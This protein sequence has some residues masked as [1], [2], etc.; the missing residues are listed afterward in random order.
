MTQKKLKSD[1]VIKEIKYE[2]IRK[3]KQ[4]FDDLNNLNEKHFLSLGFVFGL[5]NLNIFQ[6][7]VSIIG[8]EDSLFS[9]G[10][11]DLK[12]YFPYN[13]PNYPP[14]IFFVTPIYHINVCLEDGKVIL[15]TIRWWSYKFTYNIKKVLID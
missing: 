9:G 4:E 11:F 13:Y 3:L 15:E 5:E 14:E 8:P 12:I 10:L 2:S 1:D 6:W 7:R